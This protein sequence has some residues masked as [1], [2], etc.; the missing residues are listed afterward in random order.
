[1]VAR[2]FA[3]DAARGPYRHRWAFTLS[4]AGEVY[5]DF[6]DRTDLLREVDWAAVAATDFRDAQ[7]KEGIGVHSRS[8]QNRV[9][10]TLAGAAHL[11]VVEVLPSWYF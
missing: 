9:L 11:P 3:R 4:N 10:R 6:R 7:V 5:S 1:M 2:S 8:I